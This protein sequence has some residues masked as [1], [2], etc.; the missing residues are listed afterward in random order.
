MNGS[1]K[2]VFAHQSHHHYHS[3]IITTAPTA[4]N[5]LSY[6]PWIHLGPFTIPSIAG[7]NLNPRRRRLTS[8]AVQQLLCLRIRQKSD[9]ITLG[10]RLIRQA[11]LPHNGDSNSE[12]ESQDG[13]VPLGDG[14]DNF[15]HTFETI[16]TYI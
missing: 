13:G 2:V 15:T 7:K 3:T 12:S 11:V 14:E 4:A 9:F 1:I 6:T 16:C 10:T 5:A 8:A